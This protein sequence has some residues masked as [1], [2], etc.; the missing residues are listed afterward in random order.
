VGIH[1]LFS[2]RPHVMKL[3]TLILALGATLTLH[4]PAQNLLTNGDFEADPSTTGWTVLTGTTQFGGLAPGSTKSAALGNL[5]RLGQSVA[6]VVGANWQL[7]FYFAVKNTPNRAFSL[8]VCTTTN[9]DIATINLRYQ[10][11]QFNTFGGGSFGSDLGLGTV[12]FSTDAEDDGDFD[13]VGDVKNVY[14]MRI[15][16]NG[17]GSGTGTYDIQL[18]NANQTTFSRSVTGLSR[19]QN[20]SGNTA[21]PSV[22]MF[23][24]NF[25]S[26]PGFW[27]DDVS[28]ENVLLPDDP[29][30]AVVTGLP[31]FGTLPVGS[32]ATSRTIVIQNTGAASDLTISAASLTGTDAAKYTV[33]TP[34]PIIIPPNEARELIMDFAPGGVS[35][36]FSATLELTS[37]DTSSP[38]IPV[39]LPARLYAAGDSLIT[40]GSFEATP[41]TTG[42]ASSGTTAPT[43]G[44]TAGSNVSA[45]LAGPG[46]GGLTS[47]LGQAIVGTAD[48]Q[49]EF[50]VL[51]QPV[52]G[53]SFQLLIHNFG[54]ATRLDAAP[55]MLRY[56]ADVFG[57]MSGNAFVD[58]PD[59]G[60]MLTSLDQNADGDYDDA[61]TGDVKNVHRIRLIG[62]RWGTPDAT[63]DIAVTDA[64]AAVFTRSIT[65]LTENQGGLG[66]MRT[67]PPSAF[68]F[69][70]A[71]GN[72]PGFT[73]DN[74]T[75]TASA[76]PVIE[77]MFVP[78]DAVFSDS[79]G[80]TLS[81]TTDPGA[82]YSIW[83][84]DNLIDW[85]PL[86]AG[87]TG[88]TYTDGF[89]PPRTR[90]FYR[91]EKQ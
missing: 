19:Y 34:M 30:L 87:L 63:Y 31:I 38:I 55:V 82:A 79:F 70:T 13:D 68:L 61:A 17:W 25:G 23:N 20:G 71:F 9:P 15:T 45:T 4:A 64:N 1:R 76:E 54:E 41:Y 24:S 32:G 86:E 29:N 37:N 48:W 74:V 60:Q 47:T 59:L 33:T 89:S 66:N 2:Q 10:S 65:G 7:D 56:E 72:S 43:A 83:A 28:F 81:W 39:A 12:A 88:P 3:K 78:V 91:V 84:S 85:S 77:R 46:T 69:T 90:R 51:L 67:S 75:M 36:A 35:G 21:V 42:W 5:Q 62:H 14:R 57:I 26:N 80:V 50:D 22:F 27:V 8:F 11:G 49:L 16:G 53:R 73:V 44:L 40:N 52:T 58:R 18:S 6:G